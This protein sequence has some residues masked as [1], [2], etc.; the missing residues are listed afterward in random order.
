M[1]IYQEDKSNP[2][3]YQGAGTTG[4]F[5]PVSAEFP[6]DMHVANF[7]LKEQLIDVDIP[8]HKQERLSSHTNVWA[9]GATMLELL[10][11]YSHADY[12]IDPE[13]NVNGEIIDIK[14][15]K[16]PEYS[17]K[18]RDLIK[19]CLESKPAKRIEVHRLRDCIE[20]Y[21]DRIK[22][23]YE[24]SD[25]NERARFEHDS[26]LYYKRNEIN[27][28]PTGRYQPYDPESPSMPEAQKIPDLDWPV[29]FPRFHDDGPEAEG[30]GNDDGDDNN[31]DD[32]LLRGGLR[33]RKTR[34]P[35][36]R[37]P[38]SMSPY[39]LNPLLGFSPHESSF[40]SL[41]DLH[42]RPWWPSDGPSH[43]RP[44]RRR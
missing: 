43:R 27:N 40:A 32:D 21:R 19:S 12:M 42:H 20:V 6:A 38:A 7:F 23:R 15:E 31:S 33:A 10:T 36:G 9:I 35:K 4:Y 29:T 2:F 14:T 17:K 44:Y 41:A 8:K 34:L 11:L 18:L 30:E 13:Y 37:R 22:K 24:Q 26:F 5:A 1:P 3:K 39:L 16:E 28:M 25:S